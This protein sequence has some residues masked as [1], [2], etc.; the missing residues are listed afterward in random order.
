[1]TRPAILITGVA[2]FIGSQIANRLLS[3]G[4]RVIGV[5][6]F[7]PYYDPRLKAAR[8][9]TLSRHPAFELHR[10][11][12]ADTDGLTSRL[13]G[14][15]VEKVIHFAAQ[16]GVRASISNPSSAERANVAGHLS[17][18][19]ACRRAGGISH[20]VY[21]SSSSVY[22]ERPLHG[23]AF[24]EEDP[25]D[26]PVSIY[27]ATKR[28]AEI[29]STSYANLYGFPQTGLRFFSVYGPWGRPDMA[30]Y[31]FAERILAG[32][33]IDIFGE[34]RM[35]RDFTYID[36]VVDGIAGVLGRPPER[37]SNR[38]LNVGSGRSVELG[39][40][41]AELEQAL[42]RQAIKVLQPM[43]PGDVTATLANVDRL[44]RLTGYSPQVP[45]EVG[46]PRFVHWLLD[47]KSE[48]RGRAP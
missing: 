27:G 46:L 37:G 18:L 1:M 22:G 12:I 36:D 21:A 32:Q 14:E 48:S 2:G 16:P 5:D 43:Q 33:P 45:I 42:G 40:M 11:D 6:C 25:T 47:Y 19:E 29:V 8:V 17:V 15:A 24:T 28:A 34:G 10:M 7:D 30:I 20:L 35:A 4:E 23:T 44:A 31:S 26:D 3:Q 39:A 41:V 38:I 13:A 9:A